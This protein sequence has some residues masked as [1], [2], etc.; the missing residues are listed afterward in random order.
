MKKWLVFFFALLLPTLSFSVT[1]AASNDA[2][3]TGVGKAIGGALFG[4]IALKVMNRNKDED[5]PRGTSKILI[6]VLALVV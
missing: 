4:Y 5:Q 1:T 3:A 6:G 2:G